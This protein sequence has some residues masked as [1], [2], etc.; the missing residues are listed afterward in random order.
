MLEKTSQD[1]ADLKQAVRL[2]E[3]PS[4]TAK[5][6]SI[7]GSPIEQVLKKLPNG[8]QAKIQDLVQTALHKAADTALWSLDNKPETA[9][10]TLLHK[11]LVATSGAIGG[12]FGFATLAVELPISTTIMLRSI[13]DI[14]RSQGFDLD[15]FET[16]QSCIEVF[17]LG[18]PT[19]TDDTA[20][21]GY[22]AV[23]GF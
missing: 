23:R 3:T 19:Q 13:A 10:S 17:A 7:I 8:A 22:Y 5:I 18:G 12:A 21:S 20:E 4:I 2:L 1:Y 11:T 14:A 6:T 15:D 9:A 16:K